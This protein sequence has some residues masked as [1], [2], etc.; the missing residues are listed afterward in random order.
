MQYVHVL[1]ACMQGAKFLYVIYSYIP[2]GY[3]TQCIH[4]ADIVKLYALKSSNTYIFPGLF[5]Y[6]IKF[7]TIAL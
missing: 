3:G 7:C 4:N 5:A 1:T 6:G 2:D